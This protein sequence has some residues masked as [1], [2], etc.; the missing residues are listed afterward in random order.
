MK[1]LVVGTAA[2][3]VAMLALGGT[4]S[5]APKAPKANETI[6][7][8]LDVASPSGPAPVTAV[9]VFNGTGTDTRTARKAGKTDHGKDVL[10]FASGTVTVKD[11]GVRRT[12]LDKTTCTKTLSEKGVWKIAKGTGSF[13]HAKGHGH[14]KASGTIQ[15]A[16]VSGGCD[17]SAPT[18][19]ITIT[20]SGRVK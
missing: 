12:T 3:S 17:F 19:S 13:V 18:G 14:Y 2:L 15:G 7:I 11:A 5:A 6:T 4:A 16:V 9:G 8:T 20:A 10:T 1:K